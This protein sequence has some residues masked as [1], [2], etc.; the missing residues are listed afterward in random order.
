[1]RWPFTL[2]RRTAVERLLDQ[3]AAD[4]RA[5][6]PADIERRRRANA[7]RWRKAAEADPL[8]NPTRNPS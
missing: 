7:T 5:A 2:R 1:M 4:R 6:R 8:L 3:R